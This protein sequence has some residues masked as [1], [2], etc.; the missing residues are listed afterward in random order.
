MDRSRIAIII[1]AFN[2]AETIKE[3]VKSVKEY[4][5]PIVVNDCSEDKTANIAES[6]GAIVISHT[7]NQGYDGALNSG[8]R[9][10]VELDYKF[11]L[12]LDA[13]GQHDPSLLEA[14]I[15]KLKNG[16][17]IV[18]GVRSSKPRIS[19]HIF[20]FYTQHRYGVLDPLCGLKGY[21]QDVYKSIGYFDSYKSIGTELF[22]NAISSGLPFEQVSLN[23]RNRKD[24]PR[25]GRLISP[26]L[27]ILRSLLIWLC[28]QPPKYIKKQES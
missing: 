8:F 18:L 25:F 24:S 19:E 23:V 22:L 17:P 28:K 15:G 27:R 2:E 26:N 21:H 16:T 9:K 20:S 10:A 11:I 6:L 3:I 14:F 12:T 1:P 5:Q 4:G 7:E 13:D